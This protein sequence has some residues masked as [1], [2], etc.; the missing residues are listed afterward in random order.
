MR[1]SLFRASPEFVAESIFAADYKF[2]SRQIDLS[3]TCEFVDLDPDLNFL[4]YIIYYSVPESTIARCGVARVS[5][6]NPYHS[7]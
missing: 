6:P 7:N 2:V 1:R 3:N 5:R 4:P